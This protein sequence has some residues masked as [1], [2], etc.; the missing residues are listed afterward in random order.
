MKR[1]ERDGLISRHA[2]PTVPVTVEYRLTDL[3]RTLRESVIP[4]S[5]WAEAHM[6]DIV[7]A[8]Q[9]YDAAAA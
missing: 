3:G 7:L 8:Q 9:S 6:D 4:F 1:L 5:R 2:F